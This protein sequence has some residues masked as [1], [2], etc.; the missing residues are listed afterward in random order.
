MRCMV[1]NQSLN[2]K[3]RFLL[4]KEKGE[5]VKTDFVE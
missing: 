3:E 4:A 1:K 2:F 5:Q